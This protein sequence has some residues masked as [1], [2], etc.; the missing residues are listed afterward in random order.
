MHTHGYASE[1]SRENQNPSES[2]FSLD[3]FKTQLVQL[4]SQACCENAESDFFSQRLVAATGARGGGTRGSWRASHMIFHSAQKMPALKRQCRGL[5]QACKPNQ[6]LWFP[7]ADEGLP[8][9]E[10]GNLSCFLLLLWFL[11]M[12]CLG[13]DSIEPVVLSSVWFGFGYFYGEL[14]SFARHARFGDCPTV[15]FAYSLYHEQ[16]IACAFS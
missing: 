12:F 6:C 1:K 7:T 16:S 3:L 13:L 2:S 8:F 5:G 15:H 10:R 11:P 4:N 9:L 14:C